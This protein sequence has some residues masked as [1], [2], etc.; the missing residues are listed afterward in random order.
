MPYFLV[1]TAV[2]VLKELGVTFPRM[3]C[4]VSLAL[5]IKCIQYLLRRKSNAQILRMDTMKDEEKIAAMQILN[6]TLLNAILVK[7][8]LAP[9]VQLVAVKITMQYGLC[10]FSSVAFSWYVPDS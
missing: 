5:E 6:I 10:A 2:N 1:E 8:E 7:P 4:R 9:Y 3:L